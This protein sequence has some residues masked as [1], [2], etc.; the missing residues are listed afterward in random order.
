M[1]KLVPKCVCISNCLIE[2]NDMINLY[3]YGI[4]VS[5]ATRHIPLTTSNDLYHCIWLMVCLI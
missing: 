1:S 2:I 3:L 4:D 5:V